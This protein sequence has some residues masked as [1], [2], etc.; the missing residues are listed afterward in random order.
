MNEPPG[1][2]GRRYRLRGLVA[3]VIAGLAFWAL[4]IWLV[5]MLFR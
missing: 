3:A 5:V 1:P 4:V 2:P